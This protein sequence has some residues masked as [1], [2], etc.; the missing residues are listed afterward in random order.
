MRLFLFVVFAVYFSSCSISPYQDSLPEQKNFTLSLKFD[1]TWNEDPFQLDRIIVDDYG[2]L[3]RPSLFMHY[4]S[5]ITL[6]AEDGTEVPVKDFMLIDY[7]RTNEALVEVP[8]N[9]YTS[10]KF[11]LGVPPDFNKDQDPAQ[12]PSSSPLSVAG[13]QGMFWTWNTGYIFSKFEGYA[14][15][16]AVD[17][18]EFLE[19]IAIHAG[20]DE[21]YRSFQSLPFELNV[22]DNSSVIV[23][24]L[25]VD[26]IF[27][28]SQ[29]SDVNLA[30]DAVT[31][32]SN[33]PQLARDF[34]DNLTAAFKIVI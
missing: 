28:P 31:H 12:Y 9:K 34:M 18:T 24:R 7:E 19:P 3:I 20:D 8:A 11:G 14:D 29:G 27:S 5:F 1:A 30:N 25:Q 16:S 17:G 21:S 33:N 6:I 10:M 2:N 32:T 22:G 15:T 4:V 23:V 26:E 13:C